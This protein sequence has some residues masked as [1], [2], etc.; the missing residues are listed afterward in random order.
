MDFIGLACLGV[1]TLRRQLFISYFLDKLF[2]EES[3]RE[4]SLHKT[5]RA[6]QILSEVSFPKRG[7][8]QNTIQKWIQDLGQIGPRL[9]NEKFN[10]EGLGGP[11]KTATKIRALLG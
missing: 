2:S 11:I 4:Q 8:A 6:G 9:S 7:S 1:V 10:P 3:R 5:Q